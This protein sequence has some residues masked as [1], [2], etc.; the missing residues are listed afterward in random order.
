MEDN[1]NQSSGNDEVMKRSFNA[2]P[3][4]PEKKEDKPKKKAAEKVGQILS[5]KE[6]EPSIPK[7]ENEISEEPKTV[8]EK[9]IQDDKKEVTEPKDEKEAPLDALGDGEKIDAAGAY[10]EASITDTSAELSATE[11]DSPEELEAAAGLAFYES[12]EEKLQSDS[13]VDDGLIVAAAD[14][15]LQALN[16]S[17]EAGES[18]D[19]VIELDDLEVAPEDAQSEAEDR[20]PES[21][22]A[23]L[24]AVAEQQSDEVDEEP[25]DPVRTTTH[26][27]MATPPPP[28]VVSAVP[29]P[30]QGLAGSPPGH[31]PNGGGGMHPPAGGGMGP[32]NPNGFGAGNPNIQVP[33]PNVV[34]NQAAVERHNQRRGRDILLGGVVGYLVGRRRGRINTEKK[35][36]PVQEKLEKQVKGLHE[37]I[38]AQ[39]LRVR[40]AAARQNEIISIPS[41]K[42][43][44][45]RTKRISELREKTKQPDALEKI[46]KSNEVNEA[47]STIQ[48]KERADRIEKSL[49]IHERLMSPKSAER[50]TLP[51]LLEIAADIKLG[52]T[53]LR[54]MYEKGAIDQR[55]LRLVLKRYLEGERLD[56]IWPEALKQ[57]LP[58]EE[59]R[60]EKAINTYTDEPVAPIYL[61]EEARGAIAKAKQQ[62]VVSTGTVSTIQ[63]NNVP[64]ENSP[65]IQ[66][67]LDDQSSPEQKKQPLPGI[68]LIVG[69]VIIVVLLF[70]IFG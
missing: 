62:E 5:G 64:I 37:R 8:L 9:I 14:E 41:S 49:E 13:E 1:N 22:Q 57:E 35:L 15:A 48:S 21:E 3:A 69:F 45:K 68:V 59:A 20:S 66:A 52:D 58:G 40:A 12:L 38:A 26:R 61:A 47:V 65:V 34:I 17:P 33:S 46:P 44:D 30:P 19:A 39:E 67:I 2:L 28:P 60:K 31:P 16:I 27:A 54:S 42:T 51:L 25:E 24:G 56:K 63:T 50:L 6:K 11:P 55:N 7:K 10:V 32:G 18:E 53:S 43:I 23:D 36:L 4:Q 29:P 70:M